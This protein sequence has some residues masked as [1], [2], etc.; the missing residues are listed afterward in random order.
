MP[1]ERP[2]SV[3]PAIVSAFGG[4][5][6]GWVLAAVCLAGLVCVAVVGETREFERDRDTPVVNAR[7][8]KYVARRDWCGRPGPRRS[9]S[10]GRSTLGGGPFAGERRRS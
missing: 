6:F 3:A 5:V 8:P 9:S 7:R 2:V 10:V 1:R 4:F